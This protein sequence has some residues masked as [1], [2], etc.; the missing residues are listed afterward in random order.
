MGSIL[1]FCAGVL[2][3]VLGEKAIKQWAG[4]AKK[5]ADAA[6]QALKS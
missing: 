6:Q 4:K 5:A 3:G 1:L 2:V